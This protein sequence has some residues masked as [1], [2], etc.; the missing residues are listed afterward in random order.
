MPE[1]TLI[2]EYLW[3]LVVLVVL[4]GVLAADNACVMAVIVKKLPEKMRHQALFYGLAGAFLLRL[5]SLFTISFLIDMWQ[6]QAIGAVYLLFMGIKHLHQ[7]TTSNKAALTASAVTEANSF[8][9]KDF[10]MTVVKV[11]IADLAFAVDSILASVALAMSLP[12]LGTLG[13][14]G[15]MD[16]GKF[17]VI[18][19]GGFAGL[20]LMRFAAQRFV[21]L[22]DKRPSLET[23]AYL[24]VSWVGVKLLVYTLAHPVIAVLPHGFIESFAWKT[25]FW[26]VFLSICG[27]GWI[28]SERQLLVTADNESRI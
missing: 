4:E 1:T 20:V 22:L 27:G 7:N 14:I 3:V 19:S 25:A 13:Q 17:V 26:G 28:Y 11:E 10:W 6:I 24:L 8:S 16:A 12:D 9:R 5:L 18:F 2:V 23:A 21:Q 15:G